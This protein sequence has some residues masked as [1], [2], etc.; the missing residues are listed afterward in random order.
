MFGIPG[1]Y[2]QY[3]LYLA[4]M[5]LATLLAVISYLLAH[6]RIWRSRTPTPAIEGTKHRGLFSQL[7]IE[8]EAVGLYLLSGLLAGLL[9]IASAY[10]FTREENF[11][12]G[13]M[14]EI[15]RI[16][17]AASVIGFFYET[18]AM[19]RILQARLLTLLTV[20]DYVKKL[21]EATDIKKTI[22]AFIK[23]L[24]GGGEPPQEFYDSLNEDVFNRLTRPFRSE[25]AMSLKLV[26]DQQQPGVVW[27]HQTMSYMA[28]NYSTQR[29]VL[30][31]N[32]I[33]TRPSV[34]VPL[35]LEK[36]AES[37]FPGD[38]FRFHGLKINGID[39][40]NLDETIT[41]KREDIRKAKE[42]GLQG[43]E[44]EKL[45]RELALLEAHRGQ[46]K[47]VIGREFLRES[48]QEY[49]LVEGPEK[50][51]VWEEKKQERERHLNIFRV[52]FPK[53]MDRGKETH[54]Q[55]SYSMAMNRTDYYKFSVVSITEEL[56][57]TV[58]FDEERYRIVLTPVIPDYWKPRFTSD[59]PY[60]GTRVLVINHQLMPGTGF[61]VLW[62]EKEK[63]EKPYR[64]R[65]DS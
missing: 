48:D 20:P 27:L 6:T 57:V 18:A 17:V 54:V 42:Q 5:V 49:Y 22:Q 9:L 38:L 46:L 24:T 50:I 33:M 36:K 35:A 8:H 4:A 15:G 3:F 23:L 58:H 26:E 37:L 62:F 2:W 45:Q 30:F 40:K 31:E 63:V 39:K 25:C 14:L 44:L 34:E 32:D 21:H 43:V 7:G 61:V 56:K 1:E 41:E 29:E 47:D 59:S 55:Y 11:S 65:D 51:R 52:L 13:L 12:H 64:N 60:A 10:I 19:R 28:H 16:L 53:N